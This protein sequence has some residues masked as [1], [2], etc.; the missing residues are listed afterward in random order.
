MSWQTARLVVSDVILIRGRLSAYGDKGYPTS[1]DCFHGVGA[2]H[3]T[4]KR[5][6]L[7]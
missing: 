1:S 2:T 6:V 4:S 3:D 5:R 7:E